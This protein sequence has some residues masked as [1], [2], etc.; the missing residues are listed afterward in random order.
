MAKSNS[1]NMLDGPLLRPM[2]AFALP[3][4]ASGLLQQSFNS[5]DIAVAGRFAGKEALAAVGCNGPVLGTFVNLFLGL[6]VGANVVIANYIG[7]RNKRSISTAVGASYFLALVCGFLLAV[8]TQFL[9][10]PVLIALDTPAEVLE[11]AISYLKILGLG[12]PFLL[13]YNFGSAVLRSIGDTR[14]PFYSLV[15]SGLVNVGLNLVFVICM[16]MGVRGLALATVISTVINA[17]I[18][19]AVLLRVN[20][21]IRL[22]I[23]KI[24]FSLTEI[25]K[26]CRIG[27]PAG[28]QTTVFSISNVF[29]MSAINSFGADAAAGS[30]A[31]INFEFYCY[32]V[33]TAFAQT[34]T[35]FVSQNIGAG[36]PERCMRVFR[37]SLLMALASSFVLNVLMAW[38]H[39]ECLLIFTTDPEVLYF[40]GERMMY[41]LLFQ[42]VASYYEV[43][44]SSMRGMGHSLTPALI[45]IGGT[46]ML[47]LV[48]VWTFPDDASFGLLLSIYPI[49]WVATDIMMWIAF[50]RLR[51][52][53]LA[54]KS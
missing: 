46:C 12:M 31:A 35:A 20:D 38:L 9:A 6:S 2:L 3:L 45:T 5:V 4:L 39:D 24:R 23:R 10:R 19:T 37:V 30:A 48:W 29:I 7:Q 44:G 51:S 41:V 1:I 33:I 54:R 16:D 43:A 47:R 32:F 15:I 52:R 8:S 36:N 25:G 42:F 53:I 40:G 34:A 11:S 21:S 18:I 22:E 14:S 49:S 26:I 50:S 13:L 17:A 28:L 27:L